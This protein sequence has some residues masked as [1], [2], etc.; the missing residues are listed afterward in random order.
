MDGWVEGKAGLRIAYSN[1][2]LLENSFQ[3][4]LT[5]HR[6]TIMAIKILAFFSFVLLRWFNEVPQNIIVKMFVSIA[7]IPAVKKVEKH[8]S[9]SL[10]HRFLRE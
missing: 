3:L 7:R 9:R 1:Q 6:R 5:Y 4:K 8:C 10:D 2:K